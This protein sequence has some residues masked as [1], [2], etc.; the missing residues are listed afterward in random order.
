M[1]VC[2]YVFVYVY[3]YV[4]VSEY[5]CV[6][7][8]TRVCVCAYNCIYIYIYI[9]IC[10]NMHVPSSH[11][12]SAER[13][14]AAR[15]VLPRMQGSRQVHYKSKHRGQPPRYWIA[16]LRLCRMCRSLSEGGVGTGCCSSYGYLAGFI[17][18]F[19][20]KPFFISTRVS[21]TPPP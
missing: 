18:S 7:I 21:T 11:D 2:M 3:V 13:T 5:V 9:Y 19:Q 20:L 12:Y 6:V 1:Y 14:Y 16:G 8:L 10:K 4:Y 15:S 17:A